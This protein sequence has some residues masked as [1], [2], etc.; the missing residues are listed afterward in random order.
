LYKERSKYN[1]KNIYRN[2]E[3]RHRYPSMFVIKQIEEDGKNLIIER[4]ENGKSV[5]SSSSNTSN[6]HLLFYIIAAMN[7]TTTTTTTTVI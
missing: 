3:Y 1:V 2:I 5:C 6:N 4:N 7:T